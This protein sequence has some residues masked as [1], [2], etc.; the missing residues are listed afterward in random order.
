MFIVCDMSNPVEIKAMVKSVKEHFGRIDILVNNAGQ[1]YDASIEETDIENYHKIFDLNVI[2]P[3]TAMQNVIP[4][5]KDEKGGTIINVSSGTALMALPNMA[6]YSSTKRALAQIS[7]TA[8][9]ELKDKNIKVSVI[10]PYVTL[11]DF[12]KNTIKSKPEEV[13]TDWINHLPH[14]PDSSEFVA[15]VIM[16]AIMSGEVE[17]FAHDWLKK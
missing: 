7:M 2:G 15:K 1:G 13:D 12:E 14:P 17:V 4:V 10:Y 16:N 9:M 3:L 11:S 5:M 6:A 8:S